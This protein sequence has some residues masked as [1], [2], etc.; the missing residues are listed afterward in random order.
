MVVSHEQHYVARYYRYGVKPKSGGA[1]TVSPP[2]TKLRP[3]LYVHK[4]R[5]SLRLCRLRGLNQLLLWKRPYS[6]PSTG[7][8]SSLRT[9]P[10]QLTT[11]N[12]VA[13]GTL[14]RSIV[15]CNRTFAASRIT[16]LAMGAPKGS[17][18]RSN[19]EISL[20]VLS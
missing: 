12:L 14:Q 15:S 1:R 16:G 8:L 4:E 17:K 18:R 7:L 20:R 9:A 2:R 13:L 19:Y 11:S 3:G 10:P 5:F 6:S